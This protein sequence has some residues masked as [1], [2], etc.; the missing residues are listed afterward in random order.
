[1]NGRWSTVRTA[2]LQPSAGQRLTPWWVFVD[3]RTPTAASWPTLA[4][5]PGAGTA[6]EKKP[7][8]SRGRLFPFRERRLLD[9]A[10]GVH[11]ASPVVIIV[12][13]L[14]EVVGRLTENRLD[15]GWW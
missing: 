9:G 11:A 2:A 4:R 5:P 6:Q 12:A 3:Q 14:A 8:S 10:S 15:L 13:R 7:A 1:M